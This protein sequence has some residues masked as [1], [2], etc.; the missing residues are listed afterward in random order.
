MDV[1]NIVNA[2][3]ILHNICIQAQQDINFEIPINEGIAD[4][5]IPYQ[6]QNVHDGYLARERL[7]NQYFR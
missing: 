2:C 3:C 5:H 6:L 7:I 1:G 4:N